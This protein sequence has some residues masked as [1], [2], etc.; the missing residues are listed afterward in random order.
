MAQRQSASDWAQRTMSGAGHP[1]LPGENGPVPLSLPFRQIHLDFHT[2]EHIPGVGA[3]FDPDEFAAT[4]AEARVQSVNLFAKCHHGWLYL[5]TDLPWRHPN[6]RTNLLVEQV[7]A[8]HRRGIRCPVYVSVGWD[9]L[10]ARLHPDWVEQ[11]EDGRPEGA[12]PLEPGWRKLDF[13]S[14]YLD[15]VEQQVREV[16]R[17]LDGECDGF[18]FDILYASGVSGPHSL[19]LFERLGWDPESPEDRDRMR[20]RLVDECCERLS[21]LVRSLSPEVLVFHNSGHV[22]PSFRSRLNTV[23]HL[24]L[25]SLPTGG[26]GYA[27]F[28]IV[29]RYARTLGKPYLGMTGKFSESWGHFNSYK[30][31]AALELE[32]V[33]SLALGGACCVGDQLHPRGRL[34][35]E[36]Y[37]RIGR[38]FEAVEAIEPYAEGSE[39]VVEAAVLHAELWDSGSRLPD[40]NVG[41]LRML[42][43]GLVQFDFVDDQDPLEGYRLVVL[44]EGSTVPE[45]LAQALHRHV[46]RGGSVLLA[47]EACTELSAPWLPA[48]CR[49]PL[50]YS[51]DYIQLEDALGASSPIVAYDRGVRLEPKQGAEVL[52]WAVRPYFNRTWRHFCSHAHTPPEGSRYAPAVVRLG[53]VAWLA[54]PFFGMYARHP[55]PEYRDMALRWIDLLCPG[56]L[57]RHDGPK[58]IQAHLRRQ[59]S[60]WILHVLHAIPE[61]R[62]T[63]FEVV[64]DPLPIHRVRFSVRVPV[65]KVRWIGRGEVVGGHADDEVIE[66]EVRDGLGHGLAVLE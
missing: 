33:Q 49:G 29:A 47:G 51:P 3:D 2:S 34:D 21:N 27:H 32:C 54:H 59:G 4:L 28:P 7:R 65:Q 58:S 19:R 10:Q 40:A 30:P 14:P 26:W 56:R 42:T 11:H 9:E 44:P 31:A 38:A 23:T 37:R 8:L 15:V 25:E 57:V 18:W 60:R 39:R 20:R 13:A 6:L 62:G 12:P 43:E 41:A 53:N 48:E 5:D 36:T 61:R 17:V 1:L 66:F 55:M 64:E 35:R 16:W 24:E 46:D 52:A 50:E 63:S 45:R 22:G